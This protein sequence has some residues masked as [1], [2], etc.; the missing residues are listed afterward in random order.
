MSKLTP[1]LVVGLTA[2][3]N[4]PTPGN[5]ADANHMTIDSPTMNMIDAFVPG[6]PDATADGPA[7][8]ITLVNGAATGGIDV[9]FQDASGH[10]LK[11]A[12]SDASGHATYT[13]HRGSMITVLQPDG[14]NGGGTNYM[15]NTVMDVNPGDQITVG[16]RQAQIPGSSVGTGNITLVSGYPS[17]TGYDI[18]A[19]SCQTS[20]SGPG[21][22]SI[23]ID[24]RCVDPTTNKIFFSALAHDSMGNSLAYADWTQPAPP[25]GGTF[26]VTVPSWRTDFK[27]TH[28]PYSNTPANVATIQFS[29]QLYFT[30]AIALDLN[31]QYAMPPAGTGGQLSLSMPNDGMAV[32]IQ[33]NLI[34]TDPTTMMMSSFSVAGGRY[35]IST[36]PATLPMANLGVD[37]MPQLG[38]TGYSVAG[39]NPGVI[40]T[41]PYGSEAGHGAKAG[42]AQTSWT[43]GTNYYNWFV[44]FPPDDMDHKITLPDIPSDLMTYIP[45]SAATS[46][47]T[48]TVAFV[49]LDIAPDYDTY[50]ENVGSD[51]FLENNLPTTINTFRAAIGGGFH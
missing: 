37:F 31:Q 18:K 16:R 34:F 48:P 50:K 44:I 15:I 27:T 7:T 19:G 36:L 10:V 6:Q 33:E 11:H 45:P 40:W 9:L 35:T 14:M 30:N 23:N 51:I 49:D 41:E 17:A 38:P 28:W 3:G 22:T 25:V 24:A 4:I 13:V 8:V 2:C 42:L 5:T 26:P 29:G 47:N 21:M 20:L 32:L 12:M 43:M 1:L 39:P 46:L